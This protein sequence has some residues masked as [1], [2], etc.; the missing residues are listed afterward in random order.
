M[1][2]LYIYLE[3]FILYCNAYIRIIYPYLIWL[4]LLIN[5]IWQLCH[6]PLPKKKKKKKQKQNRD[7]PSLVGEG[8]V[9]FALAPPYL[10]LQ[11]NDLINLMSP[12][13]GDWP[14]CTFSGVRFPYVQRVF[15]AVMFHF[16]CQFGWAMVPCCLVKHQSRCPCEIFFLSLINI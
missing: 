15:P 5:F 7:R 8:I 14:G 6:P 1:H 12:I 16:R 11:K 10:L 9:C 3:I 4:A 2:V 13:P